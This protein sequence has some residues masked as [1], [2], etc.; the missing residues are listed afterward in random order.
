M[1][2]GAAASGNIG[3]L[4]SLLPDASRGIIALF[5]GLFL[6]VVI[7]LGVAVI[8]GMLFNTRL[9]KGK[10]VVEDL[11][12]E[13]AGL[14]KSG[15]YVSAG[16][17]HERLKDFERAAGLYEK[18]GDFSR[19]ASVYEAIGW[20][21]KSSEMHE[22][23]GDPEKAAEACLMAGDFLE[24]AK[25]YD[26]SGN[27][28][29]AAE[30]LEMAG[31]KF[32]AARAYREAKDY[33]KA[34]R[35]LKEEGMFREAAE[36]YGFT[37]AGE[38]PGESNIDRFYAYAS[39][40]EKAEE[41]EKALAIFRDI[42][43]LDPEYLDVTRKLEEAGIELTP[44]THSG[45]PGETP[46]K[47]TEGALLRETALRSLMADRLEPRYSLRLWVQIMKALDQ[48]LKHGNVVENLT[49]ES[50]SIDA[51]NTVRFDRT[52]PRVFAYVAPEIVSGGQPDQ[53]SMIYSMGIILYEMLA[54]SLDN[55][56][57]KKPSEVMPDVPSWL[58]ELTMKC[59]SRDRADRYSDL[60]EIF[61]TLMSLKSRM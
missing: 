13:A 57:L 5:V 20:T 30:A 38:K 54:G 61:S 42:A 19:A 21:D 27:R 31:N 9:R 18:G 26:R 39:L 28:A 29:K 46:A 47:N 33:T 2:S 60:G 1:T 23:A 15:Q 24:A 11:R 25:L 32:A 56:G 59:M 35:L 58:E 10:T 17:I 40:L 7:P 51:S 41:A 49:P 8:R 36:M 45:A 50:I 55:V 53:G 6:I 4:S 52:A 48:N 3:D 12:A 14:E 22:R 37:L 44:E 34:S 43:L 16:V